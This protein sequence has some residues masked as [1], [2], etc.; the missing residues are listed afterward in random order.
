MKPLLITGTNLR[1]FVR[2]RSNIFFVLIF[3]LALVLVI[4]LQFGEQQD[5]R[6]GLV[7][8]D[9]TVGRSIAERLAAAD[10]ID[11][12]LRDDPDE[13]FD[14]V[15][16]G[17]LDA[18]V[19]LPDGLDDIVQRDA[20]LEVQFA[21]TNE[22]IGP[23]LRAIVQDA[24]ARATAEQTAV[25]D[26]VGR[27]LDEPRARALAAQLGSGPDLIDVRTITT[28]ERLFPEDLAGFDIG[29]P[30]QLVLFVFLTALTGSTALIQTRRLGLSA[31]ML[32]TP[33]PLRSIIAGEALGRFA[34]A[35]VQGVYILV[36]SSLLFGVDWGDVPGAI[37]VLTMF[38]AV[39]AAAAMLAGSL[40]RSDQQAAGI[41]IIVSLALAALG[42]AML[43]IELFND[44]LLS[45]AK[46]TPHYWAIDALSELIRHDGTILVIDRQLGVLALF[47]LGIGVVAIWQARRTLTR[48]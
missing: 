19:V 7:G 12:R 2:D 23:Q 28:G 13:L 25:I 33:T 35:A 38:A 3:P 14:D 39:G 32:A 9:G 26:A 1:R 15:A 24:I 17:V 47:A 36:A 45:I 27:G 4:G 18:G 44:T 34:V 29:A 42:G 48:V 20:P 46:F 22:G 11:L 40:F 21:N 5:P 30:N 37:A 43:P 41:T 10:Q 31:R 8:A 16:S 6:V